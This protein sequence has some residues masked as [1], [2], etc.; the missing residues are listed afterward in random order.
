MYFD[1]EEIKVPFVSPSNL[2]GARHTFFFSH[3]FILMGALM[4]AIPVRFCQSSVMGAFLG[5]Q[6]IPETVLLRDL[7]I[8]VSKREVKV[9]LLAMSA[10]EKD[11][12]MD[13]QEDIL[14][15]TSKIKVD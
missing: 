12:I 11:D 10:T 14:G 8:H 3:S 7:V 13:E 2:H 1:R 4:G 6:S 5:S 15:A 9:M